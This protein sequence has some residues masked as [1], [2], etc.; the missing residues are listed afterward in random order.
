MA[1]IDKT[2]I[3]KIVESI[4]RT[5]E[6]IAALIAVISKERIGKTVLTIREAGAFLGCTVDALY[7]MIYADKIDYSKP[8]GKIYFNL[9]DLERYAFRNK[10][11]SYQSLSEQADATLNHERRRSHE[12]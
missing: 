11:L 10:H 2:E 3:A 1:E 4:E 8:D 7:Q 9:Q 6:S 12:N 5:N